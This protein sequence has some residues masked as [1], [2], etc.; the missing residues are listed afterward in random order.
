MLLA[1]L[2]LLLLSTG[3]RLTTL[4]CGG[5]GPG[6]RP[7]TGGGNCR[8]SSAAGTEGASTTDD[9]YANRALGHPTSFRL[10]PP[11]PP[12]LFIS[13]A[14]LLCCTRAWLGWGWGV[15]F[16]PGGAAVAAAGPLAPSP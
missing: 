13:A 3:F 12:L 14:Q 16:Q 8:P 11:I 4:L 15:K 1:D 7:R 9:I 5:H 2:S 10:S 6:G